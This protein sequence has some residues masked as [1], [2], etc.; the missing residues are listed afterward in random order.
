MLSNGLRNQRDEFSPL[1]MS[2][3][4]LEWS[5]NELKPCTQLPVRAVGAVCTGTGW[6]RSVSMEGPLLKGWPW[7]PGALSSHLPP[8]IHGARRLRF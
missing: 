4:V 3:Q 5:T 2:L 7:L 6:T 1:I 8:S